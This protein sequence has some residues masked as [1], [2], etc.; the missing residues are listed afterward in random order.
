MLFVA[1]GA[2]EDQVRALVQGATKPL[3]GR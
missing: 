1:G 3:R 2:V